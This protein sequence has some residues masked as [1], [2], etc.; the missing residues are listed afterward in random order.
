MIYH[1]GIT[2]TSC[3]NAPSTKVTKTYNKK[4]N[5]RRNKLNYFV[6]HYEFII[7]HPALRTGVAAVMNSVA[8]VVHDEILHGNEICIARDL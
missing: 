4:D 8:I 5:C 3:K 1:G 7:N 6:F 2:G